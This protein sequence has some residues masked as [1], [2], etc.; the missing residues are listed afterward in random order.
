MSEHIDVVKNAIE[1]K[2]PDYLPMEVIDVPGIYN[3]YHTLDPNQVELVPGTE[4]F[5]SL[6]PCCYSW[7][8]EPIG[9]TSEG[10]ILKKDQFGTLLKTP[11]DSNSCY[12]LLEH[13]LA[14]KNS[15]DGYQFPNP[16]NTD[17][18][19]DKLGRVI[20]ERYPDRFVDARID[21]G[22]YLTTQFLFGFEE[23]LLKTASNLHFVIEV[24]EAV[25]EYY[26]QLIPKYKKAGAHMISVIEDIGG[27]NGLIMN[28]DIWRKN[29]KP[30]TNKFIQAVHDAGLY[31]G[32]CIDGNS[33]DVL[34]DVLDMK[35]DVFTVFDI[36]TTGIE[37]IRKKLR[38]KMCLKASVDMQC[39]LP[40]KSSQQVGQEAHELVANFNTPQGGFICEVVRWHRPSYPQSN[41]LASVEAFNKYRKRVW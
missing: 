27:T 8:H 9:K 37:T 29:F 18:H 24:Y 21:A 38:G 6:W 28:P 23:L 20:K 26:K 2:S 15:L 10:E 14:G 5:D 7:F 40:S 35:V 31:A 36:H 11:S 32:L 12:V 30:L 3:A 41:V 25:M 39:T 17:P 16:D 34:D 22:I 13:P 4:D 1:F 19:Y 33:K